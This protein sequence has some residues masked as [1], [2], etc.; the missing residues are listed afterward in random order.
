MKLWLNRYF[1]WL[2]RLA[3]A[4]SRQGL[5]EFLASEYATIPAGASVLLVGSGGEIRRQL[6]RHAS[7]RGFHVLSLDID[8]DQRPDIVGDVSVYDFGTKRFDVVIL[9]EVLEH[10]VSPQQALDNLHGFL[11]SGGRLILSTP[12]MLPLH[13]QPHDYFRFTRYGLQLLLQK[14]RD[15]NVAERNSYFEAIDVLWL[16]LLYVGDRRARL[17]SCFI[18]PLIYF[19]KRPLSLLLRRLIPVDSMTTGYVATAI[20]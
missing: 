12:F 7:T 19:L 18:I 11:V 1:A 8:P 17:A 15:V 5:Y 2:N 13:A 20:R 9:S 16:R 6:G 3:K 14:F 10:L 4:R